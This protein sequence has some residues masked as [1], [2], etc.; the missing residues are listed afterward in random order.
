MMTRQPSE[1]S[2]PRISSLGCSVASSTCHGVSWID[3]PCFRPG[4][5]WGNQADP[6]LRIGGDL[7][8]SLSLCASDLVVGDDHLHG[9]T[10]LVKQARVVIATHDSQFVD[11]SRSAAD[12]AVTR[13]GTR[14]GL[15]ERPPRLNTW[16]KVPRAH[17]ETPERSQRRRTLEPPVANRGSRDPQAASDSGLGVSGREEAGSRSDRGSRVR[18]PDGVSHS[19]EHVL[20]S[21]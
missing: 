11:V 15:V 2:R 13:G 18:D 14:M 17:H 6:V 21:Q 4:P 1:C 10:A 16:S 12:G 8:A 7:G 20:A 9:V 3:L 19:G 5:A